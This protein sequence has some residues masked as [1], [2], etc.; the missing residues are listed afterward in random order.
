[1]ITQLG[2][3]DA[4][5]TLRVYAHVMRRGEDER[6]RLRGLVEGGDVHHHSDAH[7][8]VA[9]SGSHARAETSRRPPTSR[10]SAYGEPT[11]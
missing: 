9:S 4:R 7:S 2:H 11:S 5:F 8:S 1:V 6:E 10:S 3:T